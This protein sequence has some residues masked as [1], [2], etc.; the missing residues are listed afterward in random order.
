MATETIEIIL[1]SNVWTDLSPSDEPTVSIQNQDLS[2]HIVV[3]ESVLAPSDN[4]RTGR[5]VY[6]NKAIVS[7]ERNGSRVYARAATI[8]D[9]VGSSKISVTR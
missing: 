9:G 8:S 1:T 7:S 5:W 4:D 2:K 6:P 3:K